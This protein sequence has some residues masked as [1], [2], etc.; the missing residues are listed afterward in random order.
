MMK[1]DV[2][3]NAQNWLRCKCIANAWKIFLWALSEFLIDTKNK[4]I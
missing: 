4:K 1:V 3:F 2:K